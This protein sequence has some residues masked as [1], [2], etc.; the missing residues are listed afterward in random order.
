[1]C[2]ITAEDEVRIYY[3][4]LWP[5]TFLSIHPDYLLVHRLEPQ[6]AGH[7]KVICEW[8]FEEETI[9]RPDFDPS[10]P[11]GVL[12]PHEPAGLARVRA[13]AARD[14]V[15]LVDRRALLEQ[16]GVRA[17]VRPDARG[18]LRRRQHREPSHRPGAIRHAAAQGGP[19]APPH[20]RRRRERTRRRTATRLA[21]RPPAAPDPAR[22]RDRGGCA[23]RPDGRRTARPSRPATGRRDH[24]SAGGPGRTL[25]AP[26]PG[27]RH[28]AS[29]P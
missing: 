3:Y 11:V 1:M 26:R 14:A 5:L 9:A 29:G 8:L 20:E 21:R 2:G 16:R 25:G 22:S 6:D 10:E 23:G 13:P 17:G 27:R 28:G 19:R 7:T 15:A 24:D 4:V 12:G 18:P